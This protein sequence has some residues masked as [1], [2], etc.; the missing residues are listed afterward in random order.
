MTGCCFLHSRVEWAVSGG[1]AKPEQP[2]EESE[3]AQVSLPQFKNQFNIDGPRWVIH[4]H[5]LITS[6]SC[7]TYVPQL[8]FM[9]LVKIYY[10]KPGKTTQNNVSM[11]YN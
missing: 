7:E 10:T 5:K 6:Y 2:V 3:Q 11:L 4:N 1:T 9:C 8:L